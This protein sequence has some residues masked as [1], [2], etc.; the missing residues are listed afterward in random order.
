ME[1]CKCFYELQNSLGSKSALVTASTEDSPSEQQ[2]DNARIDPQSEFTNLLVLARPTQEQ[3]HLAHV[4]PR[5]PFHEQQTNSAEADSVR[6]QS[7]TAGGQSFLASG[8]SPVTPTYQKP[9]LPSTSRKRGVEDIPTSSSK[10]PH[11]EEHAFDLPSTHDYFDNIKEYIKE[12]YREGLLDREEYK[13]KRL[14][15]FE[16]MM[17]KGRSL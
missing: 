17:S 9:L 4:Q 2:P 12:M 5:Q 11:L 15:I 1:I 6:E 3:S 16:L 8:P 13:Q 10:K 7:S 14:E